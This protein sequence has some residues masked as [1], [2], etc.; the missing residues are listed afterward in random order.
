MSRRFEPA[1]VLLMGHRHIPRAD[2][3]LLDLAI[4]ART[5]VRDAII[6]GP[7]RP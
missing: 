1:E 2:E 7:S 6:P 4:T 5:L 3:Q